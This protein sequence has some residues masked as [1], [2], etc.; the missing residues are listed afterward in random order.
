MTP[1]YILLAINQVSPHVLFTPI[2]QDVGGT[3]VV[4]IFLQPG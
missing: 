4:V 3:A 1:Q 2:E